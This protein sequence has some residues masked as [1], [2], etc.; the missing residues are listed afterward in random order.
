MWTYDMTN[1]L[2]VEVETIIAFGYNDLY[3]RKTFV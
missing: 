3:R 2:M 1:Y